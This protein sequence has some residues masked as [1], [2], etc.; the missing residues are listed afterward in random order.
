MHCRQFLDSGY[1]LLII[2]ALIIGTI[3]IGSL[4]TNMLPFTLDQMIGASAEELSAVVQWYWWGS[5]IGIADSKIFF[6]VFQS[7]N[8]YN[9]WTSSSGLTCAGFSEFVSCSDNGLSMPQ[10]VGH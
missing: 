7:L 9:S 8:S 1:L 3:G 4:Y 10:V 6:A 2:A 5:N